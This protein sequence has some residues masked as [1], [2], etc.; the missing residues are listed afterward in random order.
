MSKPSP[1][2]E[3]SVFGIVVNKLSKGKVFVRPE[4]APG[5]QV[6]ERYQAGYKT[7]LAQQGSGLRSHQQQQNGS[8]LE[9][10]ARTDSDTSTP[11][12]SPSSSPS[13]SSH[14]SHALEHSEKAAT[15]GAGGGSS[16]KDIESPPEKG[17]ENDPYLVTWNGPDDPENPQNW[18]TTRKAFTVALI[19]LLTTS[20]YMGSAIYTP[21]VMGLA[22]W[23]GVGTVTATLGL[24]LFVVG[25]GI[26]PMIGLSAMSEIPSIG[27]APPYV[28][29]LAIFVILQIPTALVSNIAGFMILRFLAGIFGSPP[30]ATGG[31][32]MGDMFPVRRLPVMLGVWGMAAVA[33]P[34]L[35]PLIGGFASQAYGAE[36]WRWTIWP[37][38]ML[39]GFTLVVLIFLMPESSASNIL[40]KRA[41]RL[42]KV[43]GNPH[44]RSEGELEE[45]AMTGREI[46]MMTLVRP[47]TLTFFEPIVLSICLHIGLVYGIL[48]LWF[49]AFPIVFIETYGFNYGEMGIA[50]LG[51]A[52]GSLLGFGAF[53]IWDHLYYQPLYDRL[54]GKVPPEQRLW[55]GI[56]GA[57]CIPICMFGF[58]WT[59]TASIHWIVPIIFSLFFGAGTFGLF[60][61]GLGYLGE[62][63]PLYI[64]S[65]FAGNDFAR[66]MIG[67]ALPLVARAMFNNLQANG[68]EAF[69]VAWGSTLMGC[70][71]VAM[72]PIPIMLYVYGPKL[73]AWSKH[74]ASPDDAKYHGGSGRSS[75]KKELKQEA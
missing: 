67:G 66:A 44:L 10:P 58:G 46:V 52:V 55:P 36:G 1:V 23:F 53:F 40:A 8:T 74:C 70:I 21:G 60:N 49:E 41:K 4:E 17:D 18:P 61:A 12:R 43:T 50:F 68:P 47:F 20:V 45:A 11:L 31:A 71:S 64:A 13:H 51:I 42:R 35:G 19:C 2:W 63:Y 75:E 24:T 33:G 62:A 57:F 16:S 39:S 6:P 37:L 26:G 32:S 25:Y 30:L 38:L 27:R 59:S 73:R 28:A 54:E 9:P 72:I 22:Q 65:V 56:V 7:R 14:G 5:Y 15:G 3:D 29:T 69:P 34:V 48:Y